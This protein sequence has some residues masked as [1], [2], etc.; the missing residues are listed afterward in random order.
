VILLLS[1]FTF[2]F[3]FLQYVGVFYVPNLNIISSKL[4]SSLPPYDFFVKFQWLTS[5]IGVFNVILVSIGAL[6]LSLG[7]NKD[8]S[9]LAMLTLI[10]LFYFL[11]E[12]WSYRVLNASVFFMS[13][14]IA[15]ISER[16][17]LSLVK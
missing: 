2:S 3:I 9:V 7:K 11:P 1:A 5:S 13:Y 6:F 10:F 14:A 12:A 8:Y 17:K 15:N 4:F 16:V